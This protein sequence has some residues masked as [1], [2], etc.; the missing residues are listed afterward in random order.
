M[1]TGGVAG[2]PKLHD[3]GTGDDALEQLRQRTAR[4][5]QAASPLHNEVDVRLLQNGAY[6]GAAGEFVSGS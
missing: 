6:G 2:R 4:Q 5:L 1:H 3:G